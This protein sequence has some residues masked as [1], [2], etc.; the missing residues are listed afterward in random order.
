M[1]AGDFISAASALVAA[2][3]ATVGWWQAHSAR[4]AVGTAEAQVNVMREQLALE[5]SLRDDSLQP[6]FEIAHATTMLSRGGEGRGAGRLTVEIAQTAGVPL[7][8]VKVELYAGNRL[9]A[10]D[11]ANDIVYSAP[12]CRITVRAHLNAEI[13]QTPVIRIELSGTEA[14]STRQWS[15]RLVAHPETV[16]E[17]LPLPRRVPRANLAA[18]NSNDPSWAPRGPQVS[19]AP[20]DVRGRL[21]NLRRGIAQGRQSGSEKKDQGSDPDRAQKSGPDPTQKQER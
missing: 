14:R 17:L 20:D 1:D 7:D 16:N 9:I 21:T 10:P 2:A 15:K 3:A 18:R 5:R 6:R 11:E 13:A 19:R 8:D 4:R 12:G